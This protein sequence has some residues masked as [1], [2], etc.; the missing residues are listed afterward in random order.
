MYM[1]RQA[2]RE[3]YSQ[4]IHALVDAATVDGRARHDAPVPVSQLAEPQR[5]RYVA[6]TLGSRLVLLVGEDEQR[7]V[8]ELLLVQ[9]CGQL[10]G[11]CLQPLDIR[12]VHHEDHRR[13][14]RVVAPPVRPDA[15]LP[16]QVPHVEVQVFVRD[17]LDVEADGGYC[18]NYFAYL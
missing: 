10:L 2:S 14:V 6:R 1:I 17:R 9:H 4:P 16:A 12:R 5:L 3:T 11:C 15:G 13:R 7:R 18:G 8:L